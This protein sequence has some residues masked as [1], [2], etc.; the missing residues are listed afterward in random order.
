MCL[1]LN[2][3]IVGLSPTLVNTI[4][5]SNESLEL[6]RSS[7]LT[8]IEVPRNS[9]AK[10]LHKL[11]D[12]NLK[13]KINLNKATETKMI[14]YFSNEVSLPKDTDT[15]VGFCNLPMVNIFPTKTKNF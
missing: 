7:K 4:L 3:G 6:V 13:Y 15:K 2:L 9:F 1:P 11:N 12:F 10:S 8:P 14:I 5:S